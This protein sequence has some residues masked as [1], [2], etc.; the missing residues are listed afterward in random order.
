MRILLLQGEEILLGRIAKNLLAPYGSV[1]EYEDSREIDA[2]LESAAPEQE[3]L[4][5][6]P[7]E[8]EKDEELAALLEQNR[9]R[10]GNKKL[11]M[12]GAE[13]NV[14]DS[15]VLCAFWPLSPARLQRVLQ[16]AGFATVALKA[17]DSS[18]IASLIKAVGDDEAFVKEEVESFFAAL[19]Q[20]LT[21]MTKTERQQLGEAAH[22]I[23]STSAMY[24]ARGLA[25]LFL[26][27]EHLIRSDGACD[28][29]QWLPHF[30]EE[31]S[32][33][34]ADLPELWREVCHG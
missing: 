21:D 20:R 25:M 22:K 19:P 23:S 2:A 31:A 29:A 6:W 26:Q 11:L 10:A 15:G 18:V 13:R 27:L 30:T 7:A 8:A 3:C 32:R 17:I 14:V 9:R 5:C 28:F 1:E 12:I 24:G 33:C 34:S 4:V 16:G